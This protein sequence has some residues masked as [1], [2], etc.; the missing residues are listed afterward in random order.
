LVYNSALIIGLLASGA[1]NLMISANNLIL[2]FKMGKRLHRYF[3][4]Q[5]PVVIPTLSGKSASLVMI[6]GVSMY[7]TILRQ[8]GVKLLVEDKIP[9]LHYLDIKNIYEIVVDSE[10]TY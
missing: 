8:E 9:R 5:F 4:N 1:D 10:A 3:Y 2:T 7:G 6:D